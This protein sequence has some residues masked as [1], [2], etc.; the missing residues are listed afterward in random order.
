M[1]AEVASRRAFAA[2]PSAAPPSLRPSSVVRIGARSRPAD[3]SASCPAMRRDHE[4][5]FNDFAQQQSLLSE[6]SSAPETYREFL[7]RGMVRNG[8]HPIE[9][10][11]GAIFRRVGFESVAPPTSSAHADFFAAH[12]RRKTG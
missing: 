10:P 5:S 4:T 9:R 3:P 8:G 2:T 1:S 12:S 11:A 6:K 7:V